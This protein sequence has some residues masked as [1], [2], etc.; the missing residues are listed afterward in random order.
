[1]QTLN[2]FNHQSY[3]KPIDKLSQG[4][5]AF[6]ALSFLQLLLV[7]RHQDGV[8][9]GMASCYHCGTL[10]LTLSLIGRTSECE[11]C[12]ADLR[13]CKNCAWYAPGQHWDCHENIPEAVTDKQRGNFCDYFRLNDNSPNGGTNKTSQGE[14]IAR[15]RFKA[16][17]DDTPGE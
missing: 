8:H 16:L 3:H 10:I 4:Y 12:H 13:V 9:Y 5:R 15:S 17:F 1:M 14:Q 2:S 7:I 6:I 11:K